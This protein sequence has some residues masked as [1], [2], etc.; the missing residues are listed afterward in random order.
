MR[1]QPRT[2]PSGNFTARAVKLEGNIV[3]HM[4]ALEIPIGN[5]STWVVML[6]IR[7]LGDRIR[8]LIAHYESVEC[9]RVGWERTAF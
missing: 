7:A 5:I 8:L 4:A 1:S 9:A 6:E 2:T 3:T